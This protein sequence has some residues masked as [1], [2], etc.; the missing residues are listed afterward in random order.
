MADTTKPPPLPP[1]DWY[2]VD[3]PVGLRKV[4]KEEHAL[5]QQWKPGQSLK[6]PILKGVLGQ[7]REFQSR[8]ATDRV[9][10]AHLEISVSAR[11]TGSTAY[12]SDGAKLMYRVVWLPKGFSDDECKRVFDNYQPKLE[13]GPLLPDKIQS[14]K[15]S[16]DENLI[17]GKAPNYS[18]PNSY[19]PKK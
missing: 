7:L 11:L 3:T 19:G 15:G 9:H 13:Y 10:I 2:K 17:F 4:E 5:A 16:R 12:D 6:I 18:N 14:S 1:P 8:N